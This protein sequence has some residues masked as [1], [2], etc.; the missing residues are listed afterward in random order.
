M[1]TRKTLRGLKQYRFRLLPEDYRLIT[2]EFDEEFKYHPM[3]YKTYLLKWLERLNNGDKVY[4][5]FRK[6]YKDKW[7]YT[8]VERRT[9]E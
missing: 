2:C 3:K 8:I 1:I 5:L 9:H 7:W 6:K 4:D